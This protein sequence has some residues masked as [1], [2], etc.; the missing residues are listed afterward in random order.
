MGP[1]VPTKPD[2]F[3]EFEARKARFAGR[4][5]PARNM[6]TPDDIAKIARDRP[7]ND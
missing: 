2:Y 5:L 3:L 7:R 1:L 4:W 6:S